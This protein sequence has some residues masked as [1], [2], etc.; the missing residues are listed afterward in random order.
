M[1]PVTG[2]FDEDLNKAIYH[3]T[4]TFLFL[5]HEC[6]AGD[7]LSGLHCPGQFVK[8]GAFEVAKHFNSAEKLIEIIGETRFGVAFW[9]IGEK[10]DL[11]FFALG[12]GGQTAV[13][14]QKPISN[15][16]ADG[17]DDG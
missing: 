11:S 16:P 4:K 2:R 13:H 8:D 6:L 9:D 10:I 14:I 5:Q 7:E 1:L 15:E 17:R 12:F 3:Q